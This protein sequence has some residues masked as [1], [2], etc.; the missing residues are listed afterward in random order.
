M[1]YIVLD[2]EAT[3]WR[4]ILRPNRQEIIEI[5][6]YKLD[7]FG[8]VLGRFTSFIK[9][10][11]HP[12][13]STFCKRLTTIQQ[14]D[15]DNAQTF[16]FVLRYFLDWVHE[17]DDEFAIC[18]W[19]NDDLRLLE[20]DCDLHKEDK[21]FLRNYLDVKHRYNIM[22]GRPNQMLGLKAAVKHAGFSFEGDAHRAMP[23]AFN[24]CKI[25]I[26]HIDEW[27]F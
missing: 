6:A 10:I 19:G 2:L 14:S 11:V 17:E 7:E 24:L 3:C 5:G 18:A 1:R 21:A 20:Q 23:D 9:P 12:Y 27:Q 26:K 15:V 8:T 22:I 4:G 16:P 13:L 25:F